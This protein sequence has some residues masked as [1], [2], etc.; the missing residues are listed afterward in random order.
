MNDAD[1]QLARAAIDHF[2]RSGY[3]TEEL[4]EDL[5]QVVEDLLGEAP[6]ALVA[7]LLV[8][9]REALAALQAAEAE[10]DE[11]TVNDRLEEA[12]AELED[13]GIVALENAG[14]TD[15]EGREDCEDRAQAME[16]P[17]RGAVFF[18]GEDVEAAVAGHGLALT[19]VAYTG[20]VAEIGRE[21]REVLEKYG[22]AAGARGEKVEI[23]PFPWR[24]RQFTAPPA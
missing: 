17:P 23:P 13:A 14:F 5:P 6:P 24:K 22:I 4:V 21:V 16:E 9:A 11:E 10:W 20:D 15:A 7:E 12:F 3:Y 2:A 8:R 18:T 19:V 1:R